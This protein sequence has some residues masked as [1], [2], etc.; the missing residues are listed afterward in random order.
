MCLCLCSLTEAKLTHQCWSVTSSLYESSLLKT[1]WIYGQFG[2]I[3]VSVCLSVYV[4]VCVCVW[5]C[6]IPQRPV[7]KRKYDKII[8]NTIKNV[9]IMLWDCA[10]LSYFRG[11]MFSLGYKPTELRCL[12]GLTLAGCVSKSRF[13][14]CVET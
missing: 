2:T 4:C 1:H 13:L 8:G 14:P 7:A 3:F 6:S 11:Q 5:A 10:M 9:P 12:H